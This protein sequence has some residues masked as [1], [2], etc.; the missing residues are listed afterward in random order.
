MAEGRRNLEAIHPFSV[1][2]NRGPDESPIAL[3]AQGIAKVA[4]GRAVAGE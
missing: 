4:R 1:D 3:R 2:A